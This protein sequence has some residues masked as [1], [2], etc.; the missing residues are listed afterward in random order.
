MKLTFLTQYYVTVN[1]HQ[2]SE[3]TVKWVLASSEQVEGLSI[4][5]SY[6]MEY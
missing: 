5:V 4:N 3:N 1:Q 2:Y 6:F